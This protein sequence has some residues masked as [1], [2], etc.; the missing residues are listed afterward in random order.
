[1]KL[2]MCII[3]LLASLLGQESFAED[4]ELKK[5]QKNSK[6]E[7]TVVL[8]R[9][10]GSLITKS[11]F[12]R[13]KPNC[14]AEKSLLYKKQVKSK[15][16]PLLGNPA[17]RFCLSYGAVNL[18]FF[19]SERNEYDYCVFQDKSAINSWDLYNAHH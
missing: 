15:T 3:L 17:A 14:L 13:G 16:V 6:K 9:Y 7:D 5:P 19:D 1:M 11:C 18:L 8:T 12:S 2:Y 4:I 10:R